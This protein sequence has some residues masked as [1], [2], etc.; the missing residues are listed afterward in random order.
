MS[1]GT[2][3]FW[4]FTLSLI[5]THLA[6]IIL[7]LPAKQSAMLLVFGLFFAIFGVVIGERIYG[8]MKK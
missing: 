3:K 6:M 2:F 5:V 4:I 7:K 8:S 1:E